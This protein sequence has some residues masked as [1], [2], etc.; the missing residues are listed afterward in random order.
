MKIFNKHFEKDK[1]RFWNIF[2]KLIQI[3]LAIITIGLLFY[4]NL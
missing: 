4:F 2:L 1:Y 3:F